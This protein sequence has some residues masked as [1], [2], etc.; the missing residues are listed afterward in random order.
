YEAHSSNGQFPD[1]EKMSNLVV[2]GDKVYA[3]CVHRLWF[4]D[5]VG[6]SWRVVEI[7]GGMPALLPLG[8][9]LRIV[10][11]EDGDVIEHTK[12]YLE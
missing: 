6:F 10:D 7:H 9:T 5:M 2:V 11:E 8:A 1:I 12:I 4:L 3:W